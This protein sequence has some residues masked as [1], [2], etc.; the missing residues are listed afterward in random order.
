MDIKIEQIYLWLPIY[1]L[2]LYAIGRL[3]T[4]T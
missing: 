1:S 2:Y 3:L 4:G